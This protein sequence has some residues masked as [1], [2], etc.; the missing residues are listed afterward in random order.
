MQGP[1][2]ASIAVPL[3]YFVE[4]VFATHEPLS[5]IDAIV[6]GSAAASSQSSSSSASES[7]GAVGAAA[8]AGRPITWSNAQKMES[9]SAAR[10]AL[11][12]RLA[13]YYVRL[14]VTGS[15]VSVMKHDQPLQQMSP[16]PAPPVTIPGSDGPSGYGQPGR[17][18]TLAL[19]STN[20]LNEKDRV[21]L[22]KGLESQEAAVLD[23]YAAAMRTRKYLANALLDYG[24]SG[25]LRVEK[26]EVE[27]RTP[28][29][30]NVNTVFSYKRGDALE[31]DADAS[32]LS[33]VSTAAPAGTAPAATTA[34]GVVEKGL[35]SLL[36]GTSSSTSTSSSSSSSSSP[37][38]A[39][40][41]SIYPSRTPT[42]PTVLAVIEAVKRTL[43]YL[44]T[45]VEWDC[46]AKECGPTLSLQK[47]DKER[48]DVT[49]AN[50][51]SSGGGSGSDGSDKTFSRPVPPV[52][53]A[54]T[55]SPST[56]PA[57][58]KSNSE[59]VVTGSILRVL[60]RIVHFQTQRRIAGASTPGLIRQTWPVADAVLDQCMV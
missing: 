59:R 28:G 45:P 56:V 2:N 57:S 13:R 12:S 17:K 49:D 58:V 30:T 4:L 43:P 23:T 36:S 46:D 54:M 10:N 11:L 40:N 60:R 8:A 38:S 22:H 3:A 9:A 42:L 15:G 33:T 41:L 37:Y 19:C 55:T 50:G 53:T 24:W 14:S 31:A 1:I 25:Q 26:V 16:A 21:I 47:V 32:V 29:Q 51:A 6:R 44:S 52:A 35:S 39:L 5:E 18:A 48:E 27:E 7:T 34:D 20:L